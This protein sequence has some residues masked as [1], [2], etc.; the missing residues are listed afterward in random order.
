MAKGKKKK[1]QKPVGL[2][3]VFSWETGMGKITPAMR[4]VSSKGKKSK[5]N[6]KG[7]KKK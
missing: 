3:A 1:V 7:G 6:K 5:S 4:G 2:N